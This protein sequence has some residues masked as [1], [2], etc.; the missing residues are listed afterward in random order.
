MER[1]LKDNIKVAVEVTTSRIFTGI[2]E[3]TIEDQNNGVVHKQKEKIK[4]TIR[5]MLEGA[6]IEIV[7]QGSL[8][9]IFVRNVDTSAK[10]T[11]FKDVLIRRAVS[12]SSFITLIVAFVKKQF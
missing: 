6:L 9:T 11:T 3:E 4:T 2:V 8:D 10:Y 7:E 5:N 12:S 1:L